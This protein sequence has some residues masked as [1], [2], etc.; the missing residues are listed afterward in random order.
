MQFRSTMLS[1]LYF[2]AHTH[3]SS[4]E[5]PKRVRCP[6]CTTRHWASLPQRVKPSS[7]LS[8]D[9]MATRSGLKSPDESPHWSR[10][11]GLKS[12]NKEPRYQTAKRAKSPHFKTTSDSAT[13]MAKRQV[14]SHHWSCTLR[15][16]LR[17]GTNDFAASSEKY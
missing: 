4:S 8:T 5:S 3:F 15:L 14:A 13:R 10:R 9:D 16:A 11:T 6:S 2:Y 1:S 17:V 12:H 7:F